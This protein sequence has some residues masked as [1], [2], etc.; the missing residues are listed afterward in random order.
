[1]RGRI[2]ILFFAGLFAG[3]AAAQFSTKP[4]IKPP[5]IEKPVKPTIEKP[6][7]PTITAPNKPVT[8]E[9]TVNGQLQTDLGT[10]QL[11]GDDLKIRAIAGRTTH[12]ADDIELGVTV[13][14][15]PSKG[16]FIHPGA[17]ALGMYGSVQFD[18]VR[19]SFQVDPET[20]FLIYADIEARGLG[21]GHLIQ[22]H[23][24]SWSDQTCDTRYS[25]GSLRRG[26]EVLSEERA[27]TLN[28][29]TAPL[30]GDWVPADYEETHVRD[31]LNG[32]SRIEVSCESSWRLD[33]VDVTPFTAD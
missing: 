9:V 20:T 32:R 30:S 5:T 21:D 14:L 15:D 29:V 27:K 19:G 22:L 17:V 31:T 18:P 12:S 3:P 2:L 11:S 28:L 4:T 8:R 10:S 33:E 7:K 13:K 24:Y 26:S 6:E 16:D 25:M 23:V 1:M